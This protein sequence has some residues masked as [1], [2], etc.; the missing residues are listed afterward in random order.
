VPD[1]RRAAAGASAPK[2][3]PGESAEARRANE[4]R[5]RAVFEARQRHAAEHRDEVLNN[6]ARRMNDKPPARSLPIPP[7]ASAASR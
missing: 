2:P 6:T 4:A 3:S 7:P 5:N 1:R